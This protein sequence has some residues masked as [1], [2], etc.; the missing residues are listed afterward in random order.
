MSEAEI[1]SQIQNEVLRGA[2]DKARL[3]ILLAVWGAYAV[4][5]FVGWCSCR[6]FTERRKNKYVVHPRH[7]RSGS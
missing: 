7:A 6:F 3:I 4:G 2:V 5:L 1:I